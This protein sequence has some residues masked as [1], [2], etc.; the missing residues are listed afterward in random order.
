LFYPFDTISAPVSAAR[1]TGAYGS[2]V[3]RDLCRLRE[4]KNKNQ[5]IPMEK[6]AGGE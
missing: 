4:N 3:A 5:S 1:Y 2:R 6:R